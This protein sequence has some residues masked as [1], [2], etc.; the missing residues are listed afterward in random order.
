MLFRSCFRD[1]PVPRPTASAGRARTRQRNR[2]TLPS[3]FRAYETP[4]RPQTGGPP[5]GGG[6]DPAPTDSLLFVVHRTDM[7]HRSLQ[8][9]LELW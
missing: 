6:L 1:F 8:I 7:Y 4:G 3:P 9:L 5:P 2:V